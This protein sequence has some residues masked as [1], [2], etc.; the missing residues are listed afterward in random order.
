MVK[1]RSYQ[2]LACMLGVLLIAAFMR[3]WRI[4]QIPPGLHGDEAYHLLQAQ[5]ILAG[6]SLPIFIT[7]NNGYEAMVVYLVAIPLAILGP[8]TWAGRLAMAWAG[9]IGVAAAIRCGKE[10]FPGRWTGTFAGL[11]LATFFWN[12]DYSRFGSQPILAAVIAAGAMAALW[13]AARTGRRWSYAV[14]GAC[15]GLGLYA[16]VAFRIFLFIPAGTLL[17][18]W[19]SRRLARGSDH[20]SV[21]IGGL[22]AGATALLVFAPLGWFFIQHPDLFLNRFQETT[23]PLAAQA[24]TIKS[25]LSNTQIT[26]GSLFF[27]GDANW[28]QNFAGRPA[29]DVVQA[30]FFLLGLAVLIWRWRQPQSWTLWLW[31]IVG[32][33]PSILTVETPHF[34]R[35]TIVTPA[36]AL[37]AALGMELALR[38]LPRQKGRWA[39]GLALVLSIGLTTREYFVL[40]ANQPEVFAAF[41]GQVAW[42]GRALQSAPTGAALF[43][44]PFPRP[45]FEYPEFDS[46]LDYLIGPAA[47]K[48]FRTFQGQTCLVLPSQTSVP[49]VYAIRAD[50]DHTTLPALKAAFPAGTTTQMNLLGNKVD[51]SVF[52]VPAGQT[53]LVPV[54]VSK[55]VVFGDMVRLVGFT[56]KAL[57]LKPGETIH[58]TAVWKAASISQVPYKVFVHLIGPPKADGNILYAQADQQPCAD[59][60]P[61]WWWHPGEL[62]VDAYSLPL[63]ADT[64]PGAYSLQIGWYKDPNV[65][66]SAERLTAVDAAGQALGDSVHLEQ[67]VVAAP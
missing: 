21:L 15:L 46:T 27:K 32:F 57:T 12:I 55:P 48:D 31:L 51:T 43:A 11:V 50:E 59:S 65:D 4:S 63:A 30:V 39:V 49:T 42:A 2:T 47:K 52:H 35:T 17:A 61:T 7:G 38:W 36:I 44:V 18:I 53:P 29:L 23:V 14:A 9:I 10:M 3:L 26:F 8:I 6:K 40:W 28:R 24:G 66:P 58:L 13:R 64:P 56:L 45:S 54:A 67:I 33:V 34:G 37:I 25:L 41:E 20:R 60:Y 1:T 19:V 22:L 62:I 16:Y 5:L